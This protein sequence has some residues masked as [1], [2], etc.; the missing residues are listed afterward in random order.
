MQ[1][2]I[3][4]LPKAYDE[5][6][7]E[8]IKRWAKSK[9]RDEEI[10]RLIFRIEDGKIAIINIGIWTIENLIVRL[11]ISVDLFYRYPYTT[12]AI[13]RRIEMLEEKM[14]YISLD[15]E[16]KMMTDM[17]WGKRMRKNEIKITPQD[18]LRLMKEISI[19][20]PET[21]KEDLNRLIKKLERYN[22]YAEC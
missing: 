20:M 3:D 1:R 17:T 9:E 22:R 18:I 21:T 10:R 12:E 4:M 16:P 11:V 19:H 6:L 7:Y 15:D 5:K 2:C 8:T 14:F 13:R